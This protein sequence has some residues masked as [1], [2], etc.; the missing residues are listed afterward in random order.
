M[1]TVGVGPVVGDGVRPT[2]PVGV[3]LSL[4]VGVRLPL[5]VVVGSGQGQLPKVTA[6][7]A[8]GA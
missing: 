8:P 5:A 3:E 6:N 1:V 7:A 2:V 4:L